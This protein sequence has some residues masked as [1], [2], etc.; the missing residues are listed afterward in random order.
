MNDG[1]AGII[2]G[3]VVFIILAGAVALGET[4]KKESI[5]E[6]C[7]QFGAFEAQG[8]VYDCKRRVTP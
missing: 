1:M 8:V 6:H 7:D 3:M 5:A 2:A 4:Y